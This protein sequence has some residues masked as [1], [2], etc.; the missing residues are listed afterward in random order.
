MTNEM[1]ASLSKMSSSDYGS[2]PKKD[3]DGLGKAHTGQGALMPDPAIKAAQRAARFVKLGA[4]VNPRMSPAAIQSALAASSELFN[5]AV[6]D[7]DFEQ[8]ATATLQRFASRQGVLKEVCCSANEDYSAL[9]TEVEA[10]GW[11]CVKPGAAGDATGITDPLAMLSIFQQQLR[12]AKGQS[13]HRPPPEAAD[14]MPDEAGL[15]TS[16]V[17][18]RRRLCEAAVAFIDPNQQ[19]GMTNA[20]NAI[21]QQPAGA[22]L[23]AY[24]A[25][26]DQLAGAVKAYQAQRLLAL[27]QAYHIPPTAGGY[28]FYE[29]AIAAGNLGQIKRNVDD[30]EI[31]CGKFPARQNNPVPNNPPPQNNAPQQ[32]PVPNNPPPNNPPPNYPPPQPPQNQNRPNG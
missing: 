21:A 20:I 3:R 9:V 4:Q 22:Q 16:L 28:A 18:V 6:A 32:N 30:I 17:A 27:E 23:A 13:M 12:P 26:I 24:S 10:L 2:S 15:Q 31:A 25:M 19:N 8:Q 1:A 7:R 11:F 29:K 5:P 14:N